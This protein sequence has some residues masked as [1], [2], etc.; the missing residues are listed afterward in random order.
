VRQVGGGTG[1]DGEQKRGPTSSHAPRIAHS[2]AK[3]LGDGVRAY[4]AC[5][6][7]VQAGKLNLEH[8]S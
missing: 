6:K 5:R 1:D 3:A 8:G 7:F 2:G 4:A